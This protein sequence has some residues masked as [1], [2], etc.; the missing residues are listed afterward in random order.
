M[1]ET[2]AGSG[3]YAVSNSNEWLQ[4]NFVFNERLSRCENDSEIAW[5]DE[6]KK[7]IVQAN[8]NDRCYVYFDL[9]VLTFAEYLTTQVYTGTDGENDLYYHDGVGSYANADQEAG[10]YSYRYSGANPNNY[11]CFGSNESSCPA[12][13]LYRI[14]GVFDGRVKLIKSDYANSDLL[15]ADGAYG[16]GIYTNT[17]LS[18]YKGTKT[19]INRYSWNNNTNNNTWSESN[20]NTVNLNLNYL[21]YIESDWNSLIA[22]VEWQVGGNTY[23]NIYDVSVKSTYQN[24]IVNPMEDITYNAKAGLMYISD[25]GYAASQENWN[26]NLDSYN[27]DT[28]RNNNWMYMGLNEWTITRLS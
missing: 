9:Y 21:N 20:L 11:V 28:N 5:D 15:G 26:T 6:S 18:Y 16:S 1:Y 14:I 3:E 4:D 2:E 10:D 22:M 25:Y 19:T 12:D 7:V 8:S 27:N 17:S 13:N 24:E 23:Q